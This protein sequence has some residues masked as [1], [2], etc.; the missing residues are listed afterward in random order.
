[1]CEDRSRS[2]H[3]SAL[4]DNHIPIILV[5]VAGIRLEVIAVFFERGL[6]RGDRACSLLQGHVQLVFDLSGNAPAPA[7]APVTLWRVNRPVIYLH[8]NH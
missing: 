5:G 4:N 7:R 2:K 8:C 3:V 1:M 6:G